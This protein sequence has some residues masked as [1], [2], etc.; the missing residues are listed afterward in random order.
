MLYCRAIQRHLCQCDL[1]DSI[2]ASLKADIESLADEIRQLE[3]AWKQ[4]LLTSA[5]ARCR[6]DRHSDC[7]PSGNCA[8]DETDVLE[9]HNCD[10]TSQGVCEPLQN[11]AGNTAG[12][13][14]SHHGKN[15]QVY[16]HG[17]PQTDQYLG[18]PLDSDC[19]DTVI[20]QTVQ[21]GTHLQTCREFTMYNRAVKDTSLSICDTH[22]TDAN[23]QS[24]T[25]MTFDVCQGFLTSASVDAFF[26]DQ[27]QLAQYQ[28]CCSKLDKLFS[29]FLS[30]SK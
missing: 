19:N 21:T 15:C 16:E 12:T 29:V 14:Y 5:A 1:K 18:K 7:Q 22:D 10:R 9:C 20:H 30:V 17:I 25:S 13:S 4:S 8:G 11:C 26:T 28:S 3:Q 23:V 2:T 6:V 24:C 27:L